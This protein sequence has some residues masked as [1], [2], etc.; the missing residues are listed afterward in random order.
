MRA[1]VFASEF[2]AKSNGDENE[3]AKLRE[4]L[5]REAPVC[6]AAPINSSLGALCYIDERGAR[7]AV[8]RLDP[9]AP[10]VGVPF[11]MKDL[12]AAAAGLPTI[13]GARY[14]A[15]NDRQWPRRAAAARGRGDFRQD[16]GTRDGA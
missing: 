9:A 16:H 5:R 1:R 8:A 4:R 10:F 15:R 11:L 7:A 13:A 12:G 3:T 2:E 14:F 6:Q